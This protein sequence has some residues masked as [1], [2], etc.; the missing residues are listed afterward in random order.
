MTKSYIITKENLSLFV[1]K[2]M[3]AV[4][5]TA[6]YNSECFGMSDIRL[7]NATE[8][9]LDRFIDR[10]IEAGYSPYP[11][12]NEIM[13][14]YGHWIKETS[15]FPKLKQI[16]DDGLSVDMS[17]CHEFLALCDSIWERYPDLRKVS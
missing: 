17:D 3:V 9:L 13:K 15:K 4:N 7:A 16:A 5:K 14:K 8:R 10:L 1:H 2:V 11:L 12:M 6:N